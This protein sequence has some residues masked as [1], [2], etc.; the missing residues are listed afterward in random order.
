M[1]TQ[2]KEWYSHNSMIWFLL[3]EFIARKTTPLDLKRFRMLEAIPKTSGR[4]SEVIGEVCQDAR[5]PWI[6]RC[7]RCRISLISL[8]HEKSDRSELQDMWNEK[9]MKETI[10][11]NKMMSNMMLVTWV[12]SSIKQNDFKHAIDLKCWWHD[13]NVFQ[14]FP[15]LETRTPTPQK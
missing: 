7:D 11:T 13:S 6:A 2:C 14:W 12:W 10:S 5:W 8:A 9:W 4:L 15:R 1:R 3:L